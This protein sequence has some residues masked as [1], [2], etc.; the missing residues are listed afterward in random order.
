M[1]APISRT[2][3]ELRMTM[4]GPSRSLYPCLSFAVTMDAFYSR[5]SGEHTSMDDSGRP[6]LSRECRAFFYG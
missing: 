2:G 1:H 3:E 5:T 6:F 4:D